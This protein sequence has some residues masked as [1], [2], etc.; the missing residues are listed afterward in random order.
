[1]APVLE[2]DDE[3]EE[4]ESESELSESESS[5]ELERDLPADALGQMDAVLVS[6]V[7]RSC[8]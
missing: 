6:Y 4:D 1:M 8:E 3:E 5:E 7:S 2:C